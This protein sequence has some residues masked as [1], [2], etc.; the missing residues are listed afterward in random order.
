MYLLDSGRPYWIFPNSGG[1]A[2]ENC[3]IRAGK[4][5]KNAT[6]KFDQFFVDGKF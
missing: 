6:K 1:T 4:C 5:P 2:D 3:K